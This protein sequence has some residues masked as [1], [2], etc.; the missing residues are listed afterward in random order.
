M[1]EAET[2]T[3]IVPEDV[4]VVQEV[5]HL[6]KSIIAGPM[7]KS[8][9]KRVECGQCEVETVKV[10]PKKSVNPGPERA[11]QAVQEVTHL[12][13]GI[14]GPMLKS[15]GHGGDLEAEGTGLLDGGATHPLRQGTSDEIKNA[16]QVTV[17]LAHGATQLYQNPMN[18]TV[19]SETPVEP[20]VPRE[21]GYAIT[22]SRAGCVV[23][24]PRLGKIECWLRSGCPVVQKDHALAL[25]TEIERMDTEK[26]TNRRFTLEESDNSFTKISRFKMEPADEPAGGS[27]VS[28]QKFH[29]FAFQKF[30]DKTIKDRGRHLQ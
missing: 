16:A 28:V 23:K 26:R 2:A 25:I 4:Q 1:D 9:G 20:I 12:L 18:G 24:H 3:Q 10:S 15:A 5:N 17:E 19:L 22:W 27:P 21:L 30:Q 7:L 11:A 29:T 8:I 6:L 13:K 14:A